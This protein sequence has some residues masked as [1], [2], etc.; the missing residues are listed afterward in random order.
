MRGIMY[1]QNGGRQT[2][3][4]TARLLSAAIGALVLG[5]TIGAHDLFFRAP[6][7]RVTPDSEAVVDVLNGTFG[8]SENA[9]SRDRLVD[10]SLVGPA[11]RHR[12]ALERWSERDPKSTVRLTVGAAGTYV[13]GAAIAPRLLSLPATEFN[14]YLKDEGLTEIL[15]RR[16][17]QQRLGESSRERYSKYVKAILQAGDAAS[18]THATVLGYDAEI[19]PEQNPYRLD[20]GDRLS[21]RCLV[22]GHAWA[23][24]VIFA[25]GRHQDGVRR[26]APQRLITDGDGR[27]ILRI[28]DVGTWY[29]KFVAMVETTG[30]EANYESKWS[31]LSFGVGPAPRP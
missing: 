31:T 21:V 18:D 12:I 17:E 23:R 3:S 24:A 15:R 8:T 20:P 11:G 28:T 29:V 22:N 27:A 30:P 16:A 14:A 26:I 10:V 1:T 19:V 2:E 13:L 7:Y 5:V 9:I 6:S 4:V 25:G